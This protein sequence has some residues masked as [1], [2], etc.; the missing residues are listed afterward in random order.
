MVERVKFQG[1]IGTS[2]AIQEVYDRL[3]CI[4]PSNAR[5]LITGQTGTGKEL[6]A[7]ALHN[8]GPRSA[9]PFVAINAAALPP[10]LMESEL[11][12]HSRGAFTGA[13]RD[14]AGLIAQAQGGTLFLDEIAE[15]DLS[16][17]AKLLRFLESGK[18]RRV[19][20]TGDETSDIRIICAT[21]KNLK[22]ENFR[23]DL[24]WR[25]HVIGLNLQQL[26]E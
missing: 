10:Q 20:G 1:F 11:F 5:V 8:L 4:G 22:T 9:A 19:G 7:R 15:L 23:E 16:L 18:Y 24:Y 2:P 26:I 6:A 13:H 21:H 3:S 25:L 12:G 17:Q 14:Y